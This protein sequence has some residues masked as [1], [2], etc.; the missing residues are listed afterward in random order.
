MAERAFV[1][2]DGNSFYCSSERVFVPSLTRRPE[3]V[4]S[5]NGASV[6]A[7]TAEAKALH[8]GMGARWTSCRGIRRLA[9]YAPALPARA[10]RA[11][12]VREPLVSPRK[13]ERLAPRKV[14]PALPLH[15]VH[16]PDWM[17][18]NGLK[19]SSAGGWYMCCGLLE[20]KA[21]P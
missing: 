14:F 8:I 6:V 18:L 17:T 1:L 16:R 12:P 21:G 11:L 2:I 4:L 19:I 13:A 7:R 3:I 5:N 20:V 9:P 10:A 15:V